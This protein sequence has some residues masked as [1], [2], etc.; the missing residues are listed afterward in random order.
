MHSNVAETYRNGTVFITGASGF[1]GKV[2]TEKLIRSCPVK[3]VVV[4]I[5]SK[6]GRDV[7]QRMDEIY[8]NVVSSIFFKYENNTT[9][10]YNKYE[11]FTYILK[12]YYI[13]IIESNK[14]SKKCVENFFIILFLLLFILFLLLF[15]LL[16]VL[17]FFY[18]TFPK[19][20]MPCTEIDNNN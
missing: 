4:L 20:N 9:L 3:N 1:L 15:I 13:N 17:L 19:K 6:K 2:L 11:Y 10:M 8:K 5:R 7:S 12:T 18:Y 14:Y 16:S